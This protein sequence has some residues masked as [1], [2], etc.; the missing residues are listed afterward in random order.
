MNQ[1]PTCGVWKLEREIG[2]GAYGIVYSAHG[3]DG[4][5]AAVKLCRRESISPD[6]Y[7][8]ELRGARLYQTISADTGLL[9]LLD[10]KECDWGFYSV[11]ELADDEFGNRPG[12]CG[13]YR[14]KTLSRIISGE[15]A[16]PLPESIKLGIALAQGLVTLQRH[17][18][19][20][21]DI[22]P[23]NVIY[24]RGKPV[25][26]DFGLLIEEVEAVSLVGTPGYVPPENFTDSSSDVYSLGLTLKAASFGRSID[27]IGLGPTLEADTAH[28]LFPAWWR[29][30]NKATH[31]DQNRRYHSAKALLNDLKAL[32][33]KAILTRFSSIKLPAIIFITLA[34]AIAIGSLLFS[35]KLKSSSRNAASQAIQLNTKFKEVQQKIINDLDHINE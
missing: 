25:L 32:H 19:L 2:R 11:M 13:E 15:K 17:H 21:R 8:C 28:P 4:K 26:S 5:A 7:A 3:P 16:L 30:L 22:K 24:V 12:E 33:L 18:L 35:Y 10:V 1:Q 29:I 14:P 9:R 27:E 31:P 6:R 34:L 23:G 20:H